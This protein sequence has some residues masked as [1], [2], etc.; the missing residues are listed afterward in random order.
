MNNPKLSV[1]IP[2]YNEEDEIIACLESLGGQSHSDFEIIVVD[3]ASTDS[4]Y[5]KLSNLK[6]VIP[7]FTLLKQN[8]KG[9]GAAR[10]LGAKKA[11]GN[12]LIFVDADMTFSANFLAELADPIV[13]GK[14]KGT[15]SKNEY[16]SNWDNVWA[17]CWNINEGWED[18]KRHSINYP[19][20]QKVFR[21]IL[22]SEF[23]RVGGFTPGG[24]TDDYSLAEKLGYFADVVEGAVFYHQNPENL[25]EIYMQ[26]RWVAKRNY[27]IGLI[28]FGVGLIRASLPF[29][30]LTGAFK[31]VIFGQPMFI[32]FK[33]VYDMGIFAGILDYMIMGKGSK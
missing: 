5:E 16:V 10:N 8:H 22:K 14:T 3:D 30:L 23:D 4:T 25:S 29:S 13:K 11:K 2:V 27:K 26:A 21:A 7:Q 1:V 28:G 12:V 19:D 32:I 17:R 6:K 20:K 24:Y 9:P 15:F 18:K 31:S 33:T